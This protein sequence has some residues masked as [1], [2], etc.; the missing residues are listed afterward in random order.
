[1]FPSEFKTLEARAN[2]LQIENAMLRSQLRDAQ[3]QAARDS[4]TIARLG[5]V[6][7]ATESLVARFDQLKRLLNQ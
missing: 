6:W 2:A 4:A 5:K 1:M 3:E 7:A